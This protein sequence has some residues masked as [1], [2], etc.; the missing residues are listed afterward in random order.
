MK[1]S[2]YIV[3]PQYVFFCSLTALIVITKNL[4]FIIFVVI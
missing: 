4:P 1:K 3:F 2:F